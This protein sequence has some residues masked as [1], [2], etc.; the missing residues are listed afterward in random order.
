MRRYRKRLLREAFSGLGP[1]TSNGPG[2]C[3]WHSEEHDCKCPTGTPCR[4]E[5][6][7]IKSLQKESQGFGVAVSGL[8]STA[9][10][11]LLRS[12]RTGETQ[13][14]RE[15]RL[16]LIDIL[17]RDQRARIDLDQRERRLDATQKAANASNM[18]I[19]EAAVQSAKKAKAQEA[20]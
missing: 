9:L 13:G 1:L 8:I 20:S 7:L 12:E 6:Q 4:F 11:D 18:T 14:V 19:I 5:R 16:K 10:L 3:V 17:L 15:A 2:T